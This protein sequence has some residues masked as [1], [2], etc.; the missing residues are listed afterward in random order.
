MHTSRR[1]PVYILHDGSEDAVRGLSRL[2][3]SL[4]CDP[5]AL[6]TVCLSFISL[7]GKAT[8][9]VPLTEIEAIGNVGAA[10]VESGAADLDGGLSIFESD[11][12]GKLRKST[13]NTKGDW[14]PILVLFLGADPEGELSAGLDVI[15]ER[16]CGR[17]L[18]FLG[19]VVS[20]ATRTKLKVGGFD[21]ID[22]INGLVESGPDGGA[23]R[24]WNEVLCRA[25]GKSLCCAAPAAVVDSQ[26]PPFLP[27]DGV[28]PK[29]M[30]MAAAPAG[31]DEGEV[32]RPKS[33]ELRPSNL[34]TVDLGNLSTDGRVTRRGLLLY[35]LLY[36]G[37]IMLSVFIGYLSMTLASVVSTVA[38]GIFVL[39]LIKRAHDLGLSGW[40]V[41]IPF[42]GFWLFFAPGEAGP[43]KF[44]PDP[45]ASGD[46]GGSGAR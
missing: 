16:R 43:N 14:S 46:V 38:W 9:A 33:A 24:S 4:R 7:A 35:L 45:R 2:V 5:L 15:K 34:L 32:V 12:Q 40:Y 23:G 41:L 17:R 22:V 18:A 1:L 8:Q 42:F 19:G 39:G 37:I 21:L 20:A 29:S 10:L 13:A 28:N 30:R 11:A 44:G 3:D 6:E 25:I 27:H 26:P 36:V 31:P